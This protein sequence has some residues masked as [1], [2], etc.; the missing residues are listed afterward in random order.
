MHDLYRFQS[1]DT[2]DQSTDSHPESAVQV[3]YTEKLT[4]AYNQSTDGQTESWAVDWFHSQS[5]G[6]CPESLSVDW[7]LGAVN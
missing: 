3:L 7:W 4:D 2:A 5:I 6:T 1:T